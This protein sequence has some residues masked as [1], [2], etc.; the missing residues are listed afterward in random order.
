VYF[1]KK[2]TTR[3]LRKK[4]EKNNNCQSLR[5]KIIKDKIKK[6]LKKYQHTRVMK[7]RKIKIMD[8]TMKL[9]TN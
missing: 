2:L 5:I 3:N 8:S 7:L 4:T 9:K 1:L 6:K